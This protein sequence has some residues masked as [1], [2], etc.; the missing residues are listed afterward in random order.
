VGARLIFL[1][2][3]SEL[4]KTERHGAAKP[5]VGARLIF[6]SERSEL[7]KSYALRSGKP[8]SR[9]LPQ[10]D[11]LDG[12]L[13]RGD[14]LRM[15]YCLSVLAGAFVAG[16]TLT[17]AAREPAPPSRI[18]TVTVIASA[19][20]PAIWHATNGDGDVAI[21]AIVQPLPDNFV[22]NTKPLEALLRGAHLVLLPPSIRMGIFSGAWFY[23]TQSDLLHPPDNKTLWDVLDPRVAADLAK[24]CEFLHEPPERYSDN[25]PILATMRLG[26]DFRHVDYLTTHEPEDQVHA[27]ARARRVPVRRVATYDLIPS[28]EELL[29]LPAAVTGKCID[30]VIRDIDFQSRH[31]AAAAQAWAI[32]DVAGMMANWS[33]SNSY[34]CLAQLSL[35]AAAI[36]A[37]SIDDTVAAVNDAIAGGGRSIALIDIGILMR[38]GGVLDR[39]K[40]DGISITGPTASEENSR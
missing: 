2:E 32:G 37:R 22:W 8:A 26:S 24:T 14:D 20:G 1:S 9:C 19:R 10:S 7:G 34:D 40:A 29:K 12:L 13:V 39:L 35:H 25:S 4:R 21:M 36:D 11:G 33:R 17:A 38:R 15:R 27:L 6:L 3:R 18:E 28:G 31:V 30:A 16:L 23:L 5:R